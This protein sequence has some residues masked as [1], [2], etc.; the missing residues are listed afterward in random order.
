MGEE[1]KVAD[2]YESRWKHM[3]QK[4][5][6]EFIHSERQ[7]AFLVL[8]GGVAPAERDHAVGER[9]EAAVGNRHTMSVLAKITERVLRPSKGAFGVNH[10][11]GTEQRTKPCREGFGIE[12][13]GKRSVKAE[14]MLRMQLFEAIGELA[15]KHFTKHIDRQE[16]LWLRGDPARVIG[17]KTAGGYHTVYM[18][19]MLELLIPGVKDAEETDLSAKPLRVAG[20]LKQCLGAGPE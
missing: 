11:L 13:H 15:P 9:D 16:E 14:F 6:Q 1:A 3:Q 18:R 8:V 17:S 7:Q 4:S 10:P 12:K 5:A 20:D 19:M 2:A